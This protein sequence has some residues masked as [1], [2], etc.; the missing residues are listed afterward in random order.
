MLMRRWN[1]YDP[2]RLEQRIRNGQWL[3]E[4][5]DASLLL[6]QRQVVLNNYWVF[7][8]LVNDPAEIVRRLR[9]SGLDATWRSRLTAVP[10]PADRPELDPIRVRQILGRIVFVPWYADMQ[11][12]VLARISRL[13]NDSGTSGGRA[14]MATAGEADV[15]A[16]HGDRQPAPLSSHSRL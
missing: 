11:R 4:Q 12:T 14:S 13:L 6:D 3:R 9:R 1:H 16:Q 8:V 7:P 2:V 15:N 10:A 5:L